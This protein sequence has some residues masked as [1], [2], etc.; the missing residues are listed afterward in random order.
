ML[1]QLPDDPAVLKALLLAQ[2]RAF[3]T[4]L[5]TQPSSRRFDSRRKPPSRRTR[6]TSRSRHTREVELKRS[7]RVSSSFEGVQCPR[8]R[9]ARSLQARILELYEQLRLARVSACSGPA[10]NPTRARAG[11]STRPRRWPS[12][13]PAQATPRACR[14]RP[15]S[16]LAQTP[17]DAGKKKARGKRKPLPIELPRIDVVHG[18]PLPWPFP[19]AWGGGYTSWAY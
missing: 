19:Q 7:M 18:Q 13:H 2:Q 16:R 15:P 4:Q 9:T 12:L 17:A 5:N 10:A 3:E 14:R 11:S 1:A 6:P 8:G